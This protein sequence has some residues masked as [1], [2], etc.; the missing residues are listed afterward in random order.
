MAAIV[1]RDHAAAGARQRRDPARLHPVDL[2]ARR[3]AVHKDDRLALTFV[4]EGDLN[5]AVIETWHDIPFS[6]SF[7]GAPKARAIAR[8]RR[9]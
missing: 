8:R 5:V 3:K 7:R 2:F 1:E 4:K 9:A 6:A